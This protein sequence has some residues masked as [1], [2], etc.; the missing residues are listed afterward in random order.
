MENA[1]PDE[2]ATLRR[3]FGR[4]IPASAPYGVPGADDSMIAAAIGSLLASR[5]V[6][7]E[8]L[9]D[10]L[11][12][13]EAAGTGADDVGALIARLRATDAPAIDALALAVVQCYYRDDRVMAALGM[14]ARPPF[15]K[16]FSLEQGDWSLL[17]PVRRRGRIWRAV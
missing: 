6:P 7:M 14:E 3:L 13:E 12:R 8:R 17:E 9:M 5:R 4:L 11:R 1:T 10:A 15:P 16:G 2:T